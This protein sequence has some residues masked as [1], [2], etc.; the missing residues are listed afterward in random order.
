VDALKLPDLNAA[1]MGLDEGLSF[2]PALFFQKISYSHH[3]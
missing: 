3:S 2:D 1:S